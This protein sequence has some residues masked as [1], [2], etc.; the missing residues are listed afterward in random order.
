[1][2]LRTPGF[3][4]QNYV[5]PDDDS[6]IPTISTKEE[7]DALP[8]GAEFYQKGATGLRRKP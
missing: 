2:Q 8:S 7:F 5:P 6:S 1:M 3:N 4:L